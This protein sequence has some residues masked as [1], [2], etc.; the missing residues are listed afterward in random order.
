MSLQYKEAKSTTQKIYVKQ[1]IR[2][3]KIQSQKY[4]QTLIRSRTEWHL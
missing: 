1:E 3:M 4:A 2:M